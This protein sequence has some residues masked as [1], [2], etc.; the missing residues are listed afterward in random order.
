VLPHAVGAWCVTRLLRLAPSYTVERYFT[1][2][3]A[4]RLFRRAGFG[5]QELPGG[6]ARKLAAGA[7]PTAP[8]RRWMARVAGR[9]PLRAV[10]LCAVRTRLF[11]R[12]IAP[13]WR[14]LLFRV[15]A[16]SG[17]LGAGPRGA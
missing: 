17:A 6:W 11:L 8:A 5:W 3:G 2:W 7:A 1:W 15:P 10:V 12:L 4:T 14:F 13:S 16:G 9:G